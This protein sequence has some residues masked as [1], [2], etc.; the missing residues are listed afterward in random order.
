[1]ID[2][3]HIAA[4][5]L[6]QTP[7][8][9]TQNQRN[10]CDLLSQ[11]RAK[12]VQILCFPELCVSG[13]GCEDLFLSK[14]FLERIWNMTLDIASQTQGLVCVIGF[15][16]AWKGCLY[17]AAGLCADGDLVGIVPK[18]YLANQGVHYESRWFSSWQPGRTDVFQ[19]GL[20]TLPFGDISF[21]V[22]GLR[23]GIEICE[24]AWAQQRPAI[25]LSHRG[26]HI[27]LNPSAS[28]FELGKQKKRERMVID[29]SQRFSVVYVYANLVGNESGRLLYDGRA[30]IAAYGQLFGRSPA[31]SYAPF[32]A[33]DAVIRLQEP[34]PIHPH[35]D[36]RE[37]VLRVFCGRQQQIYPAQTPAIDTGCL[38]KEEEF[39][40][41][42]SLYLFDY[43]RK[44]RANGYV[45]S[46]SGGVDSSVCAIAVRFD[47]GTC[48]P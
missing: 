32:S 29:S 10:I 27:I 2:Q 3:V 15:P 39:T 9:W 20:L 37:V 38:G 11:A 35:H 23:I 36:D 33:T 16:V 47:G 21:Q 28:H 17:N 12:G 46:L 14:A 4:G 13:Y 18:R 7:L 45:V 22:D 5:V 24:D 40:R 6:H 42:L 26:V 25:D 41:A 48:Y 1:M 30:M 34:T 8:D 43:L 19:R 44:S 31:F